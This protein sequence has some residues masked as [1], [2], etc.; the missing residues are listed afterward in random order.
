[1]EEIEK[2]NRN[3][4]I[5]HSIKRYSQLKTPF[6]WRN[7]NNEMAYDIYISLSGWLGY[8]KS[9]V[10]THMEYFYEYWVTDKYNC[11]PES[12]RK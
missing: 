10:N 8:R 3:I 11:D 7:N 1:M 12:L 6:G 9:S 2:A 4:A 5:I